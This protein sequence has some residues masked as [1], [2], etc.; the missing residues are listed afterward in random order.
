MRMKI[1]VA[2][3]MA[4]ILTTVTIGCSKNNDDAVTPTPPGVK[5]LAPSGTTPAGGGTS[6]TAG[7]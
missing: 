4:A 2:A 6:A 5:T 3:I 1:L 7:K